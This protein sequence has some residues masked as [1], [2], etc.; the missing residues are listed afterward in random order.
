MELENKN[1]IYAS[2]GHLAAILDSFITFI[3]LYF[4]TKSYH[5]ANIIVLSEYR[6]AD[7]W[8]RFQLQ[9][10][11]LKPLSSQPGAHAQVHL[12]S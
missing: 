3:K 2:R 8:S 9:I 11:I 4:G 12:S 6:N 1:V 7:A 5:Y 10:N